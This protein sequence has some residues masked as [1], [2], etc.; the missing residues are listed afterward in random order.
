M[1]TRKRTEEKEELH[2]VATGGVTTTIATAAE[3]HAKKM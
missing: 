2:W 1:I 3:C